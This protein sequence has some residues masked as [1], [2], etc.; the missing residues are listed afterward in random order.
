[1]FSGREASWSVC[2]YRT[3]ETFSLTGYGAHSVQSQVIPANHPSGIA[4]KLFF[5]I[6]LRLKG[7]FIWMSN[8]FPQYLRSNTNA[9]NEFWLPFN[10]LFW[11]DNAPPDISSQ[12]SLLYPLVLW[13]G[14][15]AARGWRCQTCDRG[16][17]QTVREKTEP[18]SNQPKE[19]TR[20]WL[21]I[22]KPNLSSTASSKSDAG[23]IKPEG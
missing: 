3:S 15:R 16:P 7:S 8:P 1:M 4:R 22:G 12:T 20:P 13:A 23:R 21:P 6:A 18:L 5:E 10:R 14:I 19:V 11:W 2:A 17:D 9:S